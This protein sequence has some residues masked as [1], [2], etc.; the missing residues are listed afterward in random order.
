MDCVIIEKNGKKHEGRI[1]ACF[2]D[3][4]FVIDCDSLRFITSNAKIIGLKKDYKVLKIRSFSF[5]KR[6]YKRIY[7]V[8]ATEDLK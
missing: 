2:E 7:L 8:K 4:L 1:R 5:E 6:K 3:T